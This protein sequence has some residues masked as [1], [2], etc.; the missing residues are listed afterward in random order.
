MKIEPREYQSAMMGMYQSGFL[1]GFKAS[2]TTGKTR[3]D[4]KLWKRLK[5][6]CIQAFDVRYNKQLEKPLTEELAK[7]AERREG[8]A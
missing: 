4:D 8:G 2:R 7:E 3:A 5:V 6:K 1:D